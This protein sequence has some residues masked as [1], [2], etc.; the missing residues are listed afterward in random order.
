MVLEFTMFSGYREYKNFHDHASESE[1]TE[2]D[3][4]L[5]VG[6]DSESA[7][8][9]ESATDSNDGDGSD[10]TGLPRRIPGGRIPST[11]QGLSS[12]SRNRADRLRRRS[13]IRDQLFEF[14][15]RPDA[16]PDNAADAAEG[17]SRAYPST[18]FP[19]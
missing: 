10:N 11:L 5:N 17:T 18:G 3:Q 19:D 4:Q 9:T 12:H 13:S 14:N 6:S 1:I 7:Q 15:R 8:T 2:T 16:L